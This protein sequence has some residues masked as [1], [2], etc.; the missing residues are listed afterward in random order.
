MHLSRC[1]VTGMRDGGVSEELKENYNPL[2][3][4]GFDAEK[5]IL[6][7]RETIRRIEE[8]AES[9]KLTKP[10]HRQA[11]GRGG[12][13]SKGSADELVEG[14]KRNR[15]RLARHPLVR[16]GMRRAQHLGRPNNYTFTQSL[17]ET[18]LAPPSRGLPADNRRPSL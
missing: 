7:L 2:G 15:A 14:L 4:P 10:L 17:G 13:A 12:D 9:P 5:E 18:A 8:R 16:V 3:I 11:L 6:S 1:Y